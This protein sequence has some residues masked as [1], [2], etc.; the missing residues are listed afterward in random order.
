MTTT[1]YGHGYSERHHVPTVQEF[2]EIEAAR[3]AAA[4]ENDSRLPANEQEEGKPPAPAKDREGST[5]VN[6]P[7]HH[8]LRQRVKSS[9]S[10]THESRQQQ[11]QQDNDDDSD[12]VA[13]PDDVPRGDDPTQGSGK[14]GGEA[15]KERLKAAAGPKDKPT[16]FQAKGT[17]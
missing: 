13:D 12:T 11:Q 15:E 3:E 7:D 14:G 5:S 1:Q 6:A 17:R 2:R 4:K 9:W 10:G 16:H 8:G